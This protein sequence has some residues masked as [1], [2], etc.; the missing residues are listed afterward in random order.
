GGSDL[1][2]SSRRFVV[3]FFVCASAYFF[4]RTNR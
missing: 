2:G 1:P 4:I 3:Y